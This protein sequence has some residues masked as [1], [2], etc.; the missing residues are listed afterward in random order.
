MLEELSVQNYALIDRLS[1]SFE[2]G[3]NILTGETGAGK[4]IIVGALS[5]LLGAKAGTEVIRTGAEEAA[6][7]AVVSLRGD[8]GEAAEW[9]AERDISAE[10]GRL[11]LRRNIKSS[12]RG[13][14]YLQNVPLTRTDLADFMAIL[15]DL[16]GQHNHESL[17]RK[18]THRKYLDRFAGLEGETAEFNRI[19]LELAEQKKALE[20]SISSERD[21]DLRLEVLT[22]AVEEINQAALKSGEGRELEAEAARL[23]DFEKLA[24]LVDSAAGA[25][26]DDERSVLSLARKAHTALQNAAAIDSGLQAVQ[27]RMEDLFYEAE[28]L[29]GEFRSYRD[30]LKYDPA[31]LEEVEER[32][33]LLYRL[34]KKYAGKA[35]GVN[36]EDAILAYRDQAEAE[37]AAL[38]GAGESREK[39]KANIAALERDLSAR[40][41]SI[42]GKRKAGAEQL[43]KRIS[44][45]LANL[46]MPNARFS[47][48]V[49]PKERGG[50]QVNLVIGTWGAD[51]VEF[52]ISA[53]TGEPLKE[54]AR[55][56]SGG[57]LSRVMLAIKTVLAG[58]G[59][60][61]SKASKGAIDSKGV[62]DSHETLVFDEIDTG[63][64]GEVA[65]AVGEYLAKI[66]GRKQIFCVTHLASIAV[67]ADNHLKVEKTSDGE[68]TVTTVLVLSER[69][70]REEIA[71]MLAGDSAGTAALAHADE[72]LSRYGRPGR[73]K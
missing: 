33:A 51:E 1:L 10:D 55:I 49:A 53:N 34:K 59:A 29:A 67:R 6:V 69:E 48:P 4:S 41:A 60:S 65:L 31:R 9:L 54:L 30:D 47:V 11:I 44:E 70:R 18:E 24:A 15:F 73:K 32:L 46:G 63:I 26:F 21:R 64:G 13:A 20:T 5:F 25:F 45:I 36:D 2:G 35:G 42:T 50:G 72:L 68:R 7:S 43:G 16:H 61:E 38:T 8:N 39:L 56:A 12:G 57:E 14:I 52:L 40:A 17:L 23:G 27:R 62:I 58:T 19:F 37:I 3:L 28:D 71:R 22:Y 66:A